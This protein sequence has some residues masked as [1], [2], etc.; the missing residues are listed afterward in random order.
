MK[1]KIICFLSFV[2]IGIIVTGGILII[3]RPKEPNISIDVD[4]TNMNIPAYQGTYSW[5]SFGK[6][7]CADYA[8][9]YD[10]MKDKK[11]P[12]VLPETTL[13]IK[14]DYKPKKNTLRVNQWIEKKP[15]EQQI[16]D[17]NKIK[18]PKEKGVYIYDVVASWKE[19]TRS[20]SFAVEIK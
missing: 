2:L 8:A 13:I 3:H 14:F 4:G 5:S 7:V 10:M 12:V 6:G 20:Y 18:V 11:I 15:V 1:R 19:G 9:P 16:I 17:S